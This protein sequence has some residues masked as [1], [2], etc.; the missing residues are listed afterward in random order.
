MKVIAGRL[1]RELERKLP[2][3][4]HQEQ[5]ENFALNRR[6]LQ[7]QPGDRDKIYSLHLPQL[8]CLNKGKEHRKYE[9]GSKASVVH[10]PDGLRD[11]GRSGA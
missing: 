2:E 9:F 6:V 7:K 10:D 8:Y 3:V 5:R 4:A 1:I 11:R